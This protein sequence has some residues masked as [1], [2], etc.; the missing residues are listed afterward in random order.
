MRE[1]PSGLVV[2]SL[3]SN[4]GDTGLIP[5][6]GTKIPHAEQQQAPCPRDRILQQ[7]SPRATATELMCSA[8][9][10]ANKREAS[11][12]QRRACIPQPRPDAPKSK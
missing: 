10:T 2:E 5:R 11:T 8:A 4:V 7:R 1:L 12:L 6:R 3:P 9:L